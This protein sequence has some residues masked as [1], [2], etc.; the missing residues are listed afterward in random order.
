MTTDPYPHHSPVSGPADPVREDGDSLPLDDHAFCDA[1]A[2][3]VLV[4]LIQTG[5]HD[6]TPRELAHDAYQHADAML[7]ERRKRMGGEP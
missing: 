7:T 3:E 2:R 5:P 6:C 4:T 1:V